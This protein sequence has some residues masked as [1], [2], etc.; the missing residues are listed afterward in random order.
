[1]EHAKQANGSGFT[2]TLAASPIPPLDES[3]RV[4]RVVSTLTFR[5]RDD[6]AE[7]MGFDNADVYLH[8]RYWG[9]AA[10][11]INGPSTFAVGQGTYA[12][13]GIARYPGDWPQ[14]RTRVRWPEST[15]CSRRLEGE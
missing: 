2:E 7:A 15:V 9:D 14:P 3:R 10:Q 12:S 8:L 5:T 6:I 13:P 11:L 1:M 4:K